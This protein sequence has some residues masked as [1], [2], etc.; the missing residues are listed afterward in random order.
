[1]CCII[2]TL[3]QIIAWM[4]NLI[5]RKCSNGFHGVQ[6]Y[7][8]WQR[9]LSVQL[10]QQKH[11]SQGIPHQNQKLQPRFSIQLFFLIENY[12]FH[13]SYSLG[14]SWIIIRLAS[15]SYT[16]D[17]L[18]LMHT[19]TYCIQGNIHFHLFLLL[20]PLLCQQVNLRLSEF[21]TIF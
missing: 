13:F 1:M 19:R 4:Y 7:V 20:S 9:E 14:I 10:W 2:F 15:F 17:F 12:Q 3:Y 11:H 6:L 18:F 8:G 21:K 5:N 16:S